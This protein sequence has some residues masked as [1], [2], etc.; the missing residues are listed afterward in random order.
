MIEEK[1]CG[2]KTFKEV[3]QEVDFHI[4]DKQ[5][6]AG[7]EKENEQLKCDLYNTSANLERIT[8]ECENLQKENKE[9]NNQLYDLKELYN[10][11]I[12]EVIE[13]AKSYGLISETCL[14]QYINEYDNKEITYDELYERLLSVAVQELSLSIEDMKKRL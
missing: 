3:M 2:G 14:W 10:K 12:D 7:L 4:S 5:R 13:N 1:L 8:V 11:I 9:L 6:I